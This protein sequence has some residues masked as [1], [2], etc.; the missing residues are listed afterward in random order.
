[1]SEPCTRTTSLALV[2][3][4]PRQAST[5]SG[6][7]IRG[8]KGGMKLGGIKEISPNIVESTIGIF[9]PP[10]FIP[11]PPDP[12][13]LIFRGPSLPGAAVFALFLHPSGVVQVQGLGFRVLII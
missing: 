3:G 1:M 13:H 8:S 4:K 9:N 5:V 7:R 11:Q 6:P 10:S 2:E 12:K